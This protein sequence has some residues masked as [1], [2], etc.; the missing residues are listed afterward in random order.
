MSDGDRG[1]PLRSVVHERRLPNGLTVLV[2][3]DR[4]APVVA[5]VTHVNAGY[6]D[7][8]DALAGISHVLEHMFFKGTARRGPG[9]IGRETKALGGYLNAGTIY[10]HTSYYTVVPSA[11]LQQALDIQSDALRNSVIDAGELER[12][13][14]VIIQEA[15][16]KLDSPGAVARETL[17]EIMFDAHRMRRWR[18]GTEAVLSGFTRAHVLRFYQQL[19]RAPNIVLCIAG[20]VRAEHTFA[21]VEQYYGD[22]P[23]DPPERTPGPPEPA[24]DDFRF[25]DLSG[26][27]RQ[28]HVE[29]GWRT[30]GALHADT[31]LLDLAAS[32]LGQGRAARLYRGVRECGH[33]TEIGAS[34]YSPR[35]LGVF[36]ISA[37][38]PPADAERALDATLGVLQAARAEPPTL[39]ELHRA[40]NIF[41][42][43]MVRRFETVEGQ[44]SL[45]AEWQA[46]GDWRLF[47]MYWDQL[48]T[49]GR[50][51]L[52][53]V[54]QQWLD[55]DHAS[56]LVYR[57]ASEPAVAWSAQ[58]AVMPW[59]PPAEDEVAPAREARRRPLTG[60]LEEDG[61]HFY[62][63]ANLRAV[64]L[65]RREV[66]LV[67]VAVCFAGGGNEENEASAGLTSLMARTTIKGT[68]TRSAA[69]LAEAIESLGGALLPAVA[70]DTL[71]WMLSLPSRHLEA[72]LGLLADIVYEPVFPQAEL[73]RER[74]AALS[75]IQLLRDD[76]GRFPQRLFLETAF[77]GDA[78]GQSLQAIES[79]LRNA[80]R[81]AMADW[82]GRVVRERAPLVLVVG[83]VDADAAAEMVAARFAGASSETPGTPAPVRWP[84]GPRQN[85]IERRTAQTALVL[86]F[87]GPDRNHPD[88][89]ALRVLSAAIGGL[90]G[91]LFEELRSRR[92]LAYTVAAYPFAWPRAGAFVAYIA[93]SPEREDEARQALVAELCRLAEALLPEA[94]VVRARSYLIGSRQIA[95]QSNGA[96]M[97]ELGAA[98]MFGS[99]LREIREFEARVSAVT[100]ERI[101][102]A[103]A[104]W[105]DRTRI[106]EGIVRG[107][108]GAR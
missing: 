32:A 97:A 54:L 58:R 27:I 4:R 106:V 88:A 52:A 28:T 33:A 102:D 8:P 44:A 76:M 95:L 77:A 65:P 81:D 101:R 36:G 89:D 35:D 19:Y 15:R 66:P 64:V 18:I 71:Q 7:E 48:M 85:V 55:P 13:L 83:D 46:E 75:E 26:D 84:D 37:V 80:A 79:F 100:P 82:H 17:Y 42:A 20:D 41:E 50:D 63:A 56:V 21:L 74:S 107:T 23:A 61:V 1:F 11:A 38:T 45:L 78:Y 47:A 14:R 60:R 12:E 103:A 53:R 73:E 94:D 24:H 67:S 87:P 49:A 31:A 93:T 90:G 3:E 62:E 57:P 6:F 68:A 99:G 25:R 39:R 98:L 105:F 10:D 16:R 70:P 108:G 69:V 40:R 104:H 86:G 30:P 2:A 22:M 91:R 9:D 51:D 92:S 5:V 72:G 96:R 43:R 59:T 29:W 34:N